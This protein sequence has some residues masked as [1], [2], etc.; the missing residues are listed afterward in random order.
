MLISFKTPLALCLTFLSLNLACGK[1]E[2]TLNPS[3]TTAPFSNGDEKSSDPF[4]SIQPTALIKDTYDSQD[5][6]SLQLMRP[7][8]CGHL[9]DMSRLK[10]KTTLPDFNALTSI[11]RVVLPNFNIENHDYTETLPGIP[12][13]LNEFYAIDFR[14]YILLPKTG[15]YKFGLRSDDGSRM[16]IDGKQI[17]SANGIHNAKFVYTNTVELPEGPHKIRLQYFQGPGAWMAL[18]LY[19]TPPGDKDLSIVPEAAISGAGA[20][21]K[22]CY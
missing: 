3:L 7:G 20:N 17:V 15:K 19:W 1:N 6:L 13:G 22:F 5:T 9:F 21:E 16:Y 14:G 8:I 12:F 4:Q 2:P 10:T 18:Q 11:G